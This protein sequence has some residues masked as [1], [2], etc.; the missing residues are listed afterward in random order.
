M[1]A[2]LNELRRR[3]VLKVG[4]AYLVGAWLV[5][6]LAD[7]IFPAMRLPDWSISLVLGILVV[8]FPLALVLS[9]VFDVTPRGIEKTADESA[10]AT[11]NDGIPKPR[12]IAPSIAVLPFADLSPDHD[13]EYF[14]DGLT[15]ELL[16]V[17]SR[18]G[19]MRVASRTSS[20]AFKGKNADI[21]TVSEKLNVGHVLEGSVRKSGNLLRITGQLIETASD[22]HLWAGT[23][24]RELDDIFA[25]QDE[26]ASQIARALQ[27]QLT[28]NTSAR[29]KTENVR[30]YDLFL[31]GNGFFRLLGKNNTKRAIEMYE[32]AVEIDP[33]FDRAWAGIAISHATLALLFMVNGSDRSAAVEAAGAAAARATALA[34]DSAVSHLSTGMALNAAG[35]PDKAEPEFVTAIELDPQMHQAYYQYARAAYMQGRMEKAADLFEQAIAV[36][37]SDY[38]SS[39]LLISVYRKLGRPDRVRSTAARGVA[40]VE[41]HLE[42]HPNDVD[43]LALGAGALHEIGNDEK[44]DLWAERA[45]EADAEDNEAITYNVA[46]YYAVSGKPDRAMDLIERCIHSTSWIKRDTDLD[47][48]RSLPRFKAFMKTLE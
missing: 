33:D 20:F 7:V 3:K 26:I 47:S 8:G 29:D 30:A 28:G 5:M 37:P 6:Q 35:R 34:P 36:E 15:E 43:A 45:L 11:P 13:N 25:I 24:D 17:L 19:G 22:S 10:A 32:R 44:A 12:E 2:F 4:I 40:L 9:W 48:L 46:C 18:A 1:R 21:K 16:S 41:K 39:M 31:R 42:K 38:R 14:A 27:V 23:Y